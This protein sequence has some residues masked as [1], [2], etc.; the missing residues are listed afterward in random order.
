MVL[1]MHNSIVYACG[2]DTYILWYQLNVL[3]DSIVY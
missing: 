3:L 2:K 1:V